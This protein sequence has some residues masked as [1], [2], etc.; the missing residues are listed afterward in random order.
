MKRMNFIY[1]KYVLTGLTVSVIVLL[2]ITGRL[3]FINPSVETSENHNTGKFDRKEYTPK[4]L[5]A[6]YYNDKRY[7]K[8][9]QVKQYDKPDKY[10]DFH[11]RIRTKIGKD[12]PEYPANYKITELNKLRNRSASVAAR[13]KAVDFVERG[14]YNVPG[15]TRA[16]A[17]D[18]RDPTGN[19]WFAGSVAGGIWKTTDRGQNWNLITTDQPNMAISDLKFAPSDPNILYAGTGEG[20]PAG[21]HNLFQG[22][23]IL[24]SVDGGETWTQ[25]ASTANNPAFQI[26]GKLDI[27]PTNPDIVACANFNSYSFNS[28][29]NS[30]IYMTEDG[31]Q[32]WVQKYQPHRWVQQVIFNPVNPDIMYATINGSGVAKSVDGGESWYLTSGMVVNSSVVERIEIDISAVDP[33]YLYA[34]VTG[35]AT[36]NYANEPTVN[37][38]LYVSD[39][40][41]ETWALLVSGNKISNYDF[42]GGQ[43]WYD[44]VCRVHP[45]NPEVV[46]M[47]GVD[48][49]KAELL[50][51]EAEGED[52]FLGVQEQGTGDFMDFVNFT[53]GD[54]YGGK[55]ALGDIHDSL[56]VSVE[57]RFG[58]GKKQMAHRFE[59]PEDGGTDGDGG[60]GIPD[61][62]YEY[63]DYVEV[64]FEVWDIDNNKQLAVSFRDQGKD[65]VWNLLPRKTDGPYDEQSREYFFIHALE[66]DPVN[67]NAEVTRNGGHMQENMYFMWPYLVE[68]ATWDPDNLPES[69][70]VIN[71]GTMKIRFR[72]TTVVTDGYDRNDGPNNSDVVLGST[73]QDGIH[74]DHHNIQFHIDDNTD[75]TFYILVGNDGG[76]YYSGTNKIP[77][78]ED[79]DWTFAGNGYNTTQFYGVDKKPGANEYM[80][81]TQDN[82]SWRSPIGESAS[83]LTKYVHQIGA[84]GFEVVWNY[85]DSLKIIGSIYNNVFRRTDNGGETWIYATRGL[86]DVSSDSQGRDLAPFISKLANSK[87]NPDVLYAVGASGVWKS[88][89]FGDLWSETSIEDNW[90]YSR[91]SDGEFIV[92]STMDVTIS[93][94]NPHVVW[95]GSGM[96][97]G[98]TDLGWEPFSLHV[99]TDAGETFNPV[100]NYTTEEMGEITGIYTHPAEDSTAYALFSFAKSPKILR[101]EDLGQTWEDIS[102]FEGGDVSTNGFPDVGVYC[103]LP[104]PHE[105]STIWAGTEIGIVV[106]YDN[107]ENWQ[108]LDSNLPPV[109]VWQLVLA[110]DQVVLGTHGRGI[111]TTDFPEFPEIVII[112]LIESVSTSLSG[113]LTI[114]ANMRS[115]YDST[116]ILVDSAN[117]GQI[118]ATEE[119]TYII[120]GD[121]PEEKQISVQ[122]MSYSNG[123]AYLSEPSF[124]EYFHP[125]EVVDSYS[126]DFEDTSDDNDYVGNGFSIK[127]ELFFTGRAIHSLHSYEQETE[128]FYYLKT[129][130]RIASSDATFYYEDVAIIET[131][132]DGVEWPDDD[133]YDYVVIEGSSNG[134][135][136]LPIADGYDASADVD[137]LNAYENFQKGKSS[138][139]VS[140][141]IDLLETFNPGD[142][143]LFRFRLYS[144]QLTVGWGWAIDNVY[145][146]EDL[147]VPIGFEEDQFE[148]RFVLTAYPNPFN[149]KTSFKFNVSVSGNVR[150]QVLDINGR[151]I[152]DLNL[153]Y[154][155]SGDHTFDWDGSGLRKGLYLVR[156]SSPT[157]TKILKL[158]KE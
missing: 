50:D 31:G 110:D 57:L 121:Y 124:F 6:Q 56:F 71:W 91:S 129:P 122:L 156:M 117:I 29:F 98:S 93:L 24:K 108:L 127:T 33:D 65:T 100:P 64:P 38:D 66:Y 78:E 13:T 89:D 103:L 22:N 144:D 151:I 139:Y 131:G 134:V 9:N 123:K 119:G 145:I 47:G 35:T 3:L 77:G 135:E 150:I 26:V 82:G 8:L 63:Q 73:E 118:G 90:M 153:G 147:P 14:P 40:A 72:N 20:G 102:G 92:P 133:F 95:A 53:N 42:L 7:R 10:F 128:Y 1:N 17:I 11:H 27:H 85:Y 84:D 138:L 152:D 142:S 55:L 143:V 12:G 18:P 39:D 126:S 23:G 148:N 115:P 61:S 34:S 137:W 44:N 79:G 15:R 149:S 83:S 88:S 70:L 74:V 120:T 19:T 158:L 146:Q 58:P 4:E 81:G 68:G 104:L 59:T 101:T 97:E 75:S 46:Y 30:G 141:T 114:S 155:P 5:I 45:F 136:W 52:S 43:G 67:P 32:T 36:S 130:V 41:G 2:A 140:H 60:A 157:G 16:V 80:G 99:S 25:L 37:S 107:G 109:A 87:N 54:V 86:S 69:K 28:S 106:S 62:Q 96:Y 132:E 51:G 154:Q 111:W 113:K 112:P 48:L 116:F 125:N 105:P 49:F 94:A 21:A 76:L